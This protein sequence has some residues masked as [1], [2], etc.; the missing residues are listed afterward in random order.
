MGA[1]FFVTVF[2]DLITAVLIGIVLALLSIVYR[3]T[4]ATHIDLVSNE[5]SEKPIDLPDH[6]RIIRVDGAFFFGSS[7]AFESQVNRALDIKVM[8]IDISN[9]PFLDIT[10]IFTLKDLLATL[11]RAGVDVYIVAKGEHQQ[12]LKKL[13]IANFFNTDHFYSTLAA[14][15]KQL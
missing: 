11:R 2:V 14:A 7:N 5:S 8:I 1:V 12:Q 9:V 15:I 10:A 3:I 4:Q 6:V 13:N